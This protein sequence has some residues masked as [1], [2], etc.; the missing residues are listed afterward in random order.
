MMDVDRQIDK[1]VGDLSSSEQYD[2][3]H[4]AWT[5]ARLAQR[6]KAPQIVGSGAVPN[7]VACLNDEMLV[8]YRA[9]WALSMLAKYGQKKAVLDA[10]IIPII[11][12]LVGD[13]TKV[14]ICHQ[15]SSEI[16]FTTLGDL[17]KECLDTL[18]S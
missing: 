7:L 5:L 15:H 6:G 14:E 18:R 2:R 17:A 1:L 11:Q 3:K 12:G 8:K 10:D 13:D 16:T 4:A 9:V